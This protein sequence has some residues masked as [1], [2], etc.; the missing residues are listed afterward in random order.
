MRSRLAGNLTQQLVDSLGLRIVR[1][2]IAEGDVITASSLQAQYHVSR[3]VVRDA[4]QVLQSKGMIQPRPKTGTSVISR[5][6]WNLLDSEVIAWHRNAG[7]SAELVE[8]LEEV[9]ESYEP[10][11]ARL[12]AHRRTD[13]DLEVLRDSYEKMVSATAES[14]PGSSK[15]VEA[16]LEFHQAILAATHNIIMIRLGLLVQ[17]VLKLRDE[18]T[19]GAH[20]HNGADFLKEHHAVLCAI[21]KQQ[22]G[23]AEEAMRD[24]LDRS[25]RDTAKLRGTNTIEQ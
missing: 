12:A 23:G 1:G 4:F 17:P 20:P 18:M 7:A 14:G 11:A 8:D 25:A 21:D 19:L 5:S 3:T 16:D 10:W 24:L 6:A 2:E 22:P 13:Q 9:R 15:V